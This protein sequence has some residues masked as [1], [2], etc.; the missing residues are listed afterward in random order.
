MNLDPSVRDAAA[1]ALG[2]ATKLVGEKNIAP[3]MGKLDN[4]KEQKIKEFADKVCIK[5]VLY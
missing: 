3:H 5:T 1:E 4:L 2:T